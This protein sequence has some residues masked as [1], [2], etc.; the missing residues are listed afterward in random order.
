MEAQTRHSTNTLQKHQP[1]SP[2]LAIA[3]STLERRI[4]KMTQ[5][6]FLQAT[7]R[8][9]YLKAV[10]NTATS[11]FKA[12]EPFCRDL[13]QSKRTPR[14]EALPKGRKRGPTRIP[15][16]EKSLAIEHTSNAK[17][18]AE[19][20]Q[21]H[22]PKTRH[23][24]QNAG[25]HSWPLAI[26]IVIISILCVSICKLTSAWNPNPAPILPFSHS[27]SFELLID[28]CRKHYRS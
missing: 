8:N 11:S 2:N 22:A 5:S 7:E 23:P 26:V 1:W 15:N 28:C 16:I 6:Q 27:K 10:R 12:V 4:P 17:M 19:E 9:L 3:R 18:G 24:I 25:H 14:A 13:P 20:N 21:T